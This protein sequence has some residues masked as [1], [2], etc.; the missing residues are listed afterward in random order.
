[1]HLFSLGIE[2][3]AQPAALVVGFPQSTRQAV[4]LVS[5]CGV[6]LDTHVVLKPS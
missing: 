6:V 3:L 5:K 4:P 2:H 1:V